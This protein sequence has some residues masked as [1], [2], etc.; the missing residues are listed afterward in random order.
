MQRQSKSKNNSNEIIILC[1]RL[2]A[3]HYISTPRKMQF[4]TYFLLYYYKDSIYYTCKTLV[5]RVSA[6]I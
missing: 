2:D 1:T 4:V 6:V 5:L 3:L